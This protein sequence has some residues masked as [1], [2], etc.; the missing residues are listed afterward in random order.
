MEE[1]VRDTL[2]R[3]LGKFAFGF[4]LG[5]GVRAGERTREEAVV[6]VVVAARRKSGMASFIVRVFVFC[7]QRG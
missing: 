3:S 6:V 1:K 7:V 5:L 4:E 2:N